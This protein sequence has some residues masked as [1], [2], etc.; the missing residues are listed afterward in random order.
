MANMLSATDTIKTE[1]IPSNKQGVCVIT[2]AGSYNGYLSNYYL[3]ASISSTK[4]PAT[5]K[6]TYRP[7]YSLSEMGS[8]NVTALI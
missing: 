4:V 3:G 5:I 7:L 1:L 6:I 8:T 2:T